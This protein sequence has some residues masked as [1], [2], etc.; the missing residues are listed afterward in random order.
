MQ[1][2]IPVVNDDFRKWVLAKPTKDNESD[3]VLSPAN[4]KLNSLLPPTKLVSI[5]VQPAEK[6]GPDM[7][8][9]VDANIFSL[10]FMSW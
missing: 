8:P 4:D 5:D 2:G 3:A 10:I 6:K 1:R 9:L 7:C